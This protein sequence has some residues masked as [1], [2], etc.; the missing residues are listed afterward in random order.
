LSHF[1][2]ITKYHKNPSSGKQAVQ[3]GGMDRRSDGRTEGTAD[4]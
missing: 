3:C 1:L 2:K 4:R